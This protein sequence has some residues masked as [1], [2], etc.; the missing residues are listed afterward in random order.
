MSNNHLND[1]EDKKMLMTELENEHEIELKQIEN[2]E[3]QL[4]LDFVGIYFFF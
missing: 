1:M 2:E 3:K 4:A